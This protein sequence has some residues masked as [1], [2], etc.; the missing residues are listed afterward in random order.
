VQGV[1]WL[2][3]LPPHSK[4]PATQSPDV[5][6]VVPQPTSPSTQ[7]GLAVAWALGEACGLVAWSSAGSKSAT[8]AAG[9][10]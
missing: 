9:E 1:G 3:T 5:S 7:I 10:A 6:G 2:I 8:V 4:T